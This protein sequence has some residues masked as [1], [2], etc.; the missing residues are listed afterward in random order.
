VQV[1]LTETDGEDRVVLMER[2]KP[3]TPTAGVVARGPRKTP[4]K[5]APKKRARTR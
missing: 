5:T 1:R 2:I 3:T 4:A